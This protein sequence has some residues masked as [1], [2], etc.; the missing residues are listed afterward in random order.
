MTKWRILKPREMLHQ[1]R[2]RDG[3]CTWGQRMGPR[4]RKFANDRQHRPA[5]RKR[6]HR[7]ACPFGSMYSFLTG[8]PGFSNRRI[9]F[10]PVVGK[11]FQ[12]IGE[13]HEFLEKSRLV[14]LHCPRQNS[15]RTNHPLPPIIHNSPFPANTSTVKTQPTNALKETDV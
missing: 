15:P 2:H 7:A 8:K 12:V 14:P 10:S 5:V 13:V 4:L 11:M 9:N 3:R 6:N 1:P